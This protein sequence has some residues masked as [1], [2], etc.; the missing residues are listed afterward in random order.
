MRRF[1]LSAMATCSLTW[2]TLCAADHVIPAAMPMPDEGA[3]AFVIL[4]NFL[5]TLT[6]LEA[7]MEKITPGQVKPGQLKTSLGAM[8]GDPGLENFANKPLAIIVGPGAQTPSFAIIVPAKNPQLYLDAGVNFGML[9]G[10]A[11]GDLAILTQTPD[12]EI[13]GEKIAKAYPALL[14]TLPKGD[15]RIVVAPD[16]LLTTYGGMLGMMAQMAAAQ[17]GQPET[18]KI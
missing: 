1:I 10:K 14:N 16:K 18:A 12:G 3:Y 7:L 2:S 15:L 6:R 17:T 5:Q 13:L 4:P 8:L 9:L 11:E